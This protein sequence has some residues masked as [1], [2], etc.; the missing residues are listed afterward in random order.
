MKPLVLICST[1]VDFFLLLGHILAV[2]GFDTK[3][4]SNADESVQ[5]AAEHLPHAVVIDCRPCDL[6]ALQLCA[7][8]KHN[9]KTQGLR[10]VALIGRGAEHLQLELLKC[11]VDESFIRPISPGKLL[12]FLRSTLVGSLPMQVAGERSAQQLS[13]GDLAM[14]LG[15]FRVYRDGC[16]L[17][18]CPIEFRILRHML[19]HPG[20]VFSRTDLIRAAWPANIFVADRTVDVHIGHL[21]K[22]LR[23][24]F[25]TDP[26]RTV[27]SAGYALSAV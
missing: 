2:D 9:A 21:R 20:Q 10:V 26:I 5:F 22:T 3:L 12:D 1:D 4:A 16:E 14:D 7:A 11:G 18:L 19:K 24:G 15:A 8:L 6:D 17:H 27:R 25:R 23:A 13:H